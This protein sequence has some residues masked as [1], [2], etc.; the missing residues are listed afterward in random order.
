MIIDYPVKYIDNQEELQQLK[1][2]L[3]NSMEFALDLEADVNLHR[4]GRK[5]CLAQF[6][7]GEQCWL[8]DLRVL[9]I[10]CLREILEDPAVVKVM[11]AAS[12]DISLL[13]DLLNIQLKGL[14][15]IQTCSSLLGNG[16]RSLKHFMKEMFDLELE[17]DL[18]TSDWYRRPLTEEQLAYAATDVRFL[19]EAR[20]LQLAQ[21]E[22]ADLM[23]AAL[24]AFQK[25]EQSRFQEVN[26][27]YLR[28]RNAARLTPYQKIML[29][30]LFTVRERIA[31][32]LDLPSYKILR[33]YHLIG[34]A[35]NPPLTRADF[36]EK[37]LFQDKL[38][39]YI[40]EFLLAADNARISILEQNSQ[41]K[42]Q[43]IEL[44]RL[45]HK[46]PELPG[47]ESGTEKRIHRFIR[48]F[49]PH[50][51][52]RNLGR[53]SSSYL[54]M[55]EEEGPAVIFRA[56]I[57]A[58]TGKDNCKTE[59]TSREKRVAHLFGHDGH[60]AILTALAS[61]LYE[62]PL[63]RGKVMLLFQSA[64]GNGKGAQKVLKDK[65][66]QQFQAEFTFAMH[67]VP[68]YERGNIILVKDSFTPAETSLVINLTELMEHLADEE[69][70]KAITAAF[71][72]ILLQIPLLAPDV[73]FTYL[74]MG[75]LTASE[76]PLK[77][78]IRLNLVALNDE[79]MDGLQQQITEKVESI[80]YE[81]RIKS[82]I[83]I[84]ASLPAAVNAPEAEEILRSALENYDF[85]LLEKPFSWKDDFGHYSR[86]SKAIQFGFGTG[87]SEVELG[88]SDYDFPDE[89]IYEGVEILISILRQLD[90]I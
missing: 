22:T 90:M 75:K 83:Q 54:Y 27:P 72:N 8:L 76:R 34:L 56:E 18:Q 52:I 69:Y 53:F 74:Q 89:L 50:H 88:S 25:V 39:D 51:T 64:S 17:K 40:D 67:N 85:T 13:A 9:D 82:E 44:R 71:S 4:Y 45:L 41:I 37:E 36:E 24:D 26:D 47:K 43:V 60:M 58:G 16:R 20:E 48:N 30:E 32:A 5:L 1:Q 33:S 86:I 19:L 70:R 3:E 66:F 11:Y 31:E 6:W 42:N 61:R 28:V 84:T 77:A 12:F 46:H 87:K 2:V 29:K 73:E 7:N 59:W 21:L 62:Q 63:R 49:A 55:S 81:Y 14:F 35:Q 68:Q 79:I 38:K 10:S 65:R 23:E 15:D 57:D 80:C 78:E